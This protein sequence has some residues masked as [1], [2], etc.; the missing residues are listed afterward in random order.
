[1]HAVRIVYRVRVTGGD[2]RDEVDG[3]T[4]T[5]AWF[6][7]R[8]AASLHLGDL[9]RRMLAMAA[10]DAPVGSATTAASDA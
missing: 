7:R 10:S 5:C 2:L 6:T 1:M 3:S 8:E 4:D 9:A